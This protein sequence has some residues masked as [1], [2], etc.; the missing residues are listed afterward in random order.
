[1]WPGLNNGFYVDAQVHMRQFAWEKRAPACS[2]GRSWQM[3]CDAP[4]SSLGPGIHADV[5]FTHTTYLNIVA[6]HVL[7]FMAMVFP[8]A[9]GLFHQDKVPHNT[10]NI[11]QG[12]FKKHDSVDMVQSYQAS[13]RMYWKNKVL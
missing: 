6:D 8:N 7:P 12:Q 11:V 4:N 3:N 13:V 1:M 2:M 10:A 5:T 9:F